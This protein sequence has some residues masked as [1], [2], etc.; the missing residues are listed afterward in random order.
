M[1]IVSANSNLKGLVRTY[2][3]SQVLDAMSGFTLHW[4]IQ[5][6]QIQFGVQATTAG[7]IAIGISAGLSKRKF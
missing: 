5:G 1:V 4:N 7:W 6:N 3:S 2:S